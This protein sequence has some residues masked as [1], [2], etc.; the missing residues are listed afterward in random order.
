ME[1]NLEVE[2]AENLSRLGVPSPGAGSQDA[3]H[4]SGAAVTASTCDREATALLDLRAH[5]ARLAER[6]LP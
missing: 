5:A 1:G 4:F 3:R 2:V 6:L